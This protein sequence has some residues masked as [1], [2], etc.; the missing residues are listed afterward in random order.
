MSGVFYVCQC[1]KCGLCAVKE[2]R[3]P[4]NRANYTCKLER[5]RSNRKLKSKNRLGVDINYWGPFGLP[6]EATLV[7]QERNALRGE[8]RV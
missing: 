4:L 5:C 8:K 6:K 1:P 2:V 3:V 7:A